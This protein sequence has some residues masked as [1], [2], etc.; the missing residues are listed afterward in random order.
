M[1]EP[2]AF[3]AQPSCSNRVPSE[4]FT[5]LDQI[6]NPPLATAPVD[7][8]LEGSLSAEFSDESLGDVTMPSEDGSLVVWL[9][10]NK[11]WCHIASSSAKRVSRT[12]CTETPSSE[13]FVGRH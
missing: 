3:L 5:L 6:L 9:S 8:P 12:V 4:G 11:H 1:V 13:S 10:R 2:R 7:P